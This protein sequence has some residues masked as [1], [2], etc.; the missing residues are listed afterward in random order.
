MNSILMHKTIPV[1]DVD[2]D[3]INGRIKSIGSVHAAAH[4]PVGVF[5]GDDKDIYR[6]EGWWHGRSIPM[7][8]DGLWDGNRAYGC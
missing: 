8:R 1:M 5:F 3:T 2:I 4:L 6:F 7:S